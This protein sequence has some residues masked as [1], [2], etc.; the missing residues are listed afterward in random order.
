MLWAKWLL[1]VL[2]RLFSYKSISHSQPPS[3]G[4]LL[5]NW[6]VNCCFVNLSIY[7]VVI[8]KPLI[9]S[10]SSNPSHVSIIHNI[11]QIIHTNMLRLNI[12][13]RRRSRG[14]RTEKTKCRSIIMKME[15]INVNAIFM[16]ACFEAIIMTTENRNDI[17]SCLNY[18]FILFPFRCR[19]I[20]MSLPKKLCWA[21]K[22]GQISNGFLDFIHIKKHVSAINNIVFRSECL[23]DLF[24]VDESLT[25][26]R[27]TYRISLT[28][29]Q[30][31]EKSYVCHV[32]TW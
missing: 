3:P 16:F 25:H 15:F 13:R 18:G 31:T 19:K 28:K 7:I 21:D 23:D 29:S 20:F 17:H 9:R 30:I 24:S 27:N 26:E 5:E 22:N 2:F 8:F 10:H 6:Q 11:I 4:S 1:L 32:F 14:R 12:R